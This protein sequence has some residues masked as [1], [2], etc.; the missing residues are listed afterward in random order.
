MNKGNGVNDYG[1]TKDAIAC[2]VLCQKTDLCEWF[3]WDKNKHC[4][5]KT[6]K[7]MMSRYETGGATG[8]A[9]CLGKYDRHIFQ[10]PG[11]T[12]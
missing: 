8:P 3:N 7:G 10:K 2:Q 4:W 5:L 6:K 11:D 1:E 9:F 12:K